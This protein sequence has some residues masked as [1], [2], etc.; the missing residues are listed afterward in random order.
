MCV[1]LW[2]AK[3]TATDAEAIN[4]SGSL[5]MQSWRLA[6]HLS[7]N[8]RYET[9][10]IMNL[11]QHFDSSISK[12]ALLFLGGRTD[13]LGKQY[14]GVRNEWY[15]SM[16]PLLLEGN[17]E[18]FDDNVPAFVDRIDRMVGAIQTNSEAKLKNLH[19]VMLSGLILLIVISVLVLRHIKR[20]FVEPITALAFAANRVRKRDFYIDL[21]YDNTNE[22]GKLT[23]TFVEMT[24]DLRTLYSEL[25]EQVEH[26]TTALSR[27][28]SALELLYSA[29]R[30][31]ADN[32]F[33]RVNIESLLDRWQSL[34]NL[35]GCFLCLS[36]TEGHNWLQRIEHV[37]S[38]TT[39]CEGDSCSTC[40]SNCK[41]GIPCASGVVSFPVVVSQ[42]GSQYGLLHVVPAD[43]KELGNEEQQW[44][45]VLV[46]ILATS[47]HQYRQ[48]EHGSRMLL[49][50]ERTV[51]ARELHDSLA[52]SLSYQKIQIA[53]LRRM[54][55][56]QGCDQAQTIVDELQDGVNSSYK[57]LREL[58]VTFR[59]SMTEGS[60]KDNVEKTL[61]DFVKRAEDIRFELD[62]QVRFQPFYGHQEV[63]I[64]QIIREALSNVV[65]HA[66]AT[67]CRVRC[68]QNENEQM[69]VT[70]DDNGKGLG[71]NPDRHGHYGLSIIQERANSLGGEVTFLPSPLGGARVQL[72]FS[73][74]GSTG[75]ATASDN[76]IAVEEPSA[77]KFVEAT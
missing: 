3:I 37:T 66:Q 69:V 5:R 63:H 28:N 58:L 52:Q 13:D 19:T 51:I 73:A 47:L 38:T 20:N 62:Y 6:D 27:S 2:Y 8:G 40:L 12:P 61:A 11:I 65:Q 53:R 67:T 54:L 50:E 44:L 45:Q 42:D 34:L 70:I 39:K 17:Y 22:L 18:E 9:D 29:T 77:V 23:E 33:D 26:Q 60:L 15:D 7:V 10:E 55:T 74:S 14:R 75:I 21:P 1:S 59:L 16:R 49:M 24:G 57:Q 68:T 41:E 32:P 71:D 43:G 31:L 64:L 30:S 36:S 25:E 76:S 35:E 48:K 56:G 46:D 72:S 4:V